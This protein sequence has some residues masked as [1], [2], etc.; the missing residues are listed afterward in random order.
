MN[1]ATNLDRACQVFGWGGGT[2]HEVARQVGMPGR[3]SE[4]VLMP[5]GE[6]ERVLIAHFN[7]KGDQ[8][9]KRIG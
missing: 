3:G 6:F 2:I 8:K 7:N 9:W 4:L 5:P 1:S